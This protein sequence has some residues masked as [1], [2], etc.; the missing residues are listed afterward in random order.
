MQFKD[1]SALSTSLMHLLHRAGQSADELFAAE[2]GDSDLTPRQY[3]VLTVLAEHD[4][5]SQTEIVDL[6]GIDRSTLADIV[7]RLVQRGLLARRRSKLDARAYAVR[8]TPGGQAALKLADPAAERAGER[9]LRQIP[10]S[11]RTDLYEALNLLVE[12]TRPDTSHLAAPAAK[13]RRR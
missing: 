4:T 5:A 13:P 2:M 10:P 3:A 1:R 6:T 12:P 9:M 11:R 8:L 7:K